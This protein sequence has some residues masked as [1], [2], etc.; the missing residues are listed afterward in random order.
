M[1][2]VCPHADTTARKK[3][4][5]KD[6]LAGRD[7]AVQLQDILSDPHPSS[8]DKADEILGKILWSFTQGISALSSFEAKGGDPLSWES[9]GENKLRQG[10]KGRGCY[11]RRRGSHSWTAV[12]S[13]I[14]DVYSWRKYGQKEILNS[15]FP[16]GYYRCTHKH[17]QGCKATKQVQRMEEDPNMYQITYIGQHTCREISRAPKMIPDSDPWEFKSP[18]SQIR[19]HHENGPINPFPCVKDE[20]KDDSGS[21]LTDCASGFNQDWHDFPMIPSMASDDLPLWSFSDDGLQSFSNMSFLD[22]CISFDGDFQF[23]GSDHL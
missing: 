5:F 3:R 18:E 21:D 1:S 14:E 4:I 15:R 2:G 19:N 11:K 9:P 12:N 8:A 17:D 10:E 23:A 16:R 6:L 13:A 22:G 7:L 20:H